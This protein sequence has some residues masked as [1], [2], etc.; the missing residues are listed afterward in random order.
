MKTVLRRKHFSD[1]KSVWEAT[2]AYTGEL[3]YTIKI[4]VVEGHR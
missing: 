2:D 4:N 1:T 3:L